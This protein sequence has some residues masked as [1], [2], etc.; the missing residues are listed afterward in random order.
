LT[1]DP[2]D[3]LAPA[4][5][6]AEGIKGWLVHLKDLAQNAPLNAKDYDQVNPVVGKVAAQMTVARG[7]LEPVLL[8]PPHHSVRWEFKE[9]DKQGDATSNVQICGTSGIRWLVPLKK[10][11]TEISLLSSLPE[12]PILKLAVTDGKTTE[13][14]L[15][16]SLAQDIECPKSLPQPVDYHFKLFYK[17]LKGFSGR[18]FVPVRVS[19]D[20]CS[21]VT[22]GKR[23]QRGS[24]CLGGQWP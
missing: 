10:G 22:N 12:R 11:T 9:G 3:A 24:D 19:E 2:P 14:I 13:V 15:G 5:L 7:T 20:P 18:E 23:S 6:N 8:A 21:E 17:M 16:N 4:P 1:I